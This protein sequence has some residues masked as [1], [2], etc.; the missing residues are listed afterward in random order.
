MTFKANT[1]DRDEAIRKLVGEPSAV[2]HWQHIDIAISAAALLIV[3]QCDPYKNADLNRYAAT[4]LRQVA[5]VLNPPT[6]AAPTRVC[7]ICLEQ[8][9]FKLP[10]HWVCQNETCSSFLSP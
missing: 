10:G 2:I 1:P 6:I 9:A 7:K 4:K 5:D 3:V 8:Q